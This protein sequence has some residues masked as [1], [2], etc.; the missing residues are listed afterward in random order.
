MGTKLYYVLGV[1]GGMV[2]GGTTEQFLTGTVLDWRWW[3]VV[4]PACWVWT[5]LLLPR[6]LK[7]SV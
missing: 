6:L 2:I 3:A 7:R 4:V 5:W 1:V